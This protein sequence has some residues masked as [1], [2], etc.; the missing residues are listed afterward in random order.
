M[1]VLSR[2]RGA[3]RV[4]GFAFLDIGFGIGWNQISIA[5]PSFHGMGFPHW[6][7]NGRSGRFSEMNRGGSVLATQRRCWQSGAKVLWLG[8]CEW[9]VGKS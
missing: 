9:L 7:A 8:G 1:G 5:W 4:E 2:K 3:L 6:C